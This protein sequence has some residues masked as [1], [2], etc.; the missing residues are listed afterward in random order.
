VPATT[1]RR[2]E[3]Q[4]D[5]RRDSIRSEDGVGEFDESVES[6]VEAAVVERVAEGV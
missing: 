6:A 4:V 5:G 3:A 2:F 1:V